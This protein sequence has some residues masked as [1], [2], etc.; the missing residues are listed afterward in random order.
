MT[1]L[2]R[3][4]K[5]TPRI[6]LPFISVLLLSC[7]AVRAQTIIYVSTHGAGDG[8]SW[9]QPSGL[10]DAVTSAPPDAQIW[11]KQGIYEMTQTLEFQY[12]QSGISLFGGFNGTETNLN[13]RD[14]E[15][16]ETILDGLNE[17]RIVNIDEERIVLDGLTLRHGFVT[18]ENEGGAAIYI[19][20]SET[21]LRNC[22]FFA[23]V[24]RGSRGAG[25]IYNRSGSGLLIENC[26]FENNEN[27]YVEYPN[28]S[29]GG[30]AIHNWADEV[31]IIN[32]VFRNNS[33]DN[34]GGAIYTWYDDVTKMEN[35]RF[36]RN[37]SEGNGGAI[38]ARSQLAIN[39]T[40]FID[41]TSIGGGGAIHNGRSLT[42]SHV[43]FRGNRATDQGG[44]LYTEGAA[45]ITNAL[46]DE[47][48]AG[49]PGGAIYNRGS[50]R[51][52]NVTFVNNRNSAFVFAPRISSGDSQYLYNSIFYN[53]SA[54]GSNAPD[55][56]NA[57]PYAGVTDLVIRH[58][59]L[60][61]AIEPDWGSDNLVGVNP[62]FAD[63][64]NGN[65]RPQSVS[66]LIDAGNTGLYN[67]VSDTDAG[68]SIDLAGNARL[69]GGVIDM[70][71]YEV[72]ATPPSL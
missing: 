1:D 35:C 16:N 17:R 58:N 37:H 72:E 18:G 52:S 49:A 7:T 57:S 53:N 42:L 59:S 65:Y 47:N 24:S 15:S 3:K 55:I 66:P 31:T 43:A 63:P 2:L 23:N 25:A 27:P 36:V 22:V 13:Q 48:Q 56:M 33:S 38:F 41:N 51:L 29:N 71:A 9:T 50:V 45:T 12:G 8:S 67:E 46:F 11:L 10:I 62:L 61:E 34:P 54:T 40:D 19:R 14:Y 64:A 32:T 20:D 69:L 4:A 39:N 68:A 70:G 6:V 26:L 44:S 21:Q 5:G 60:Q 28:G 30:G